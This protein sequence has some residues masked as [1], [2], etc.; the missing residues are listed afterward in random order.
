LT[1]VYCLAYLAAVVAANLA[2]TAV[3]GAPLS[4]FLAVDV[5]V[6]FS[7]IA[8]DLV[9]RD[10]LHERWEGR[11]LWPRMAA[12][13]G[14]GGLLSGAADGAAGRI[15][16]AASPAS[17]ASGLAAAAVWALARQRP[18]LERVLRS[19]LAGALT[20]SLVWPTVALGSIVPLVTASEFAA[21]VLGGAVW[22]FVLTRTIWREAVA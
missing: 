10:A 1:A 20:D 9:V 18:R 4:T 15:A 17:G 19:N 3:A 11:S 22:A 6:C 2:M 16:V 14:A 13:I 12:L 8:V 7:L 5:L 21:K